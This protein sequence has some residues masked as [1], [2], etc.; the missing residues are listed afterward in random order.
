MLIDEKFL[1]SYST[2]LSSYCPQWRNGLIAN[3]YLHP[4]RLVMKYLPTFSGA[5][6]LD[7]GCGDGHFSFFLLSQGLNVT[8]YSFNDIGSIASLFNQR[9]KERFFFRHGETQEPTILPFKEGEFDVIFSMGVLEHVWETGGNELGSLKEIHRSLKPGGKVFVFHFPNRFSWI[10]MINRA[11]VKMG[12]FQKYTHG[13]LYT[14]KQIEELAA[15]SGFLL[16]DQGLYNLFPRNL[17][18]KCPKIIGNNLFVI[19]LF[20]LVE[21]LLSLPLKMFSQNHFFVLEKIE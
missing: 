11:C 8:A 12:L 3:Q 15:A 9:F 18:R 4:C 20:H 13:R 17:L 10:E 1:T 19:R 5:S 21:R 14:K 2:E 7:W 6:V 16:R